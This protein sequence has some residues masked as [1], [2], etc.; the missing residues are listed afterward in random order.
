MKRELKNPWPN[1]PIT[2]PV[3]RAV[4]FGNLIITAG[5]SSRD[6]NTRKMPDGD[7]HAMARAALNNVKTAIEAAGGKMENVLNIYCHLRDIE[8]DFDAWN[9]VYREFFP[10]SWP[11]RTTVQ[12]VLR[13]GI[14][15][16]I[17]A[18]G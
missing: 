4:K 12:A 9:D 7:M 2:V 11:A 10:N 1:A 6:P 13:G 14:P 18:I 15:I 5:M 3:T 17:S 8:N 16:E